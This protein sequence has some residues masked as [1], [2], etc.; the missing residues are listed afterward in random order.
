MYDAEICTCIAYQAKVDVAQRISGQDK[1]RTL[2]CCEVVRCLERS[3]VEMSSRRQVESS[4]YLHQ[5]SSHELSLQLFHQS[6]IRGVH[7]K[8]QNPYPLL[9]PS[10]VD[11]WHE[12]YSKHVGIISVGLWGRPA[13]PWA[14]RMRGRGHDDGGT[15]IC[16]GI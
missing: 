13:R 16:K 15:E 2:V 3:D 8:K 12:N 10:C 7:E 1:R 4:A 11:N 6:A 9:N 14:T 5:S